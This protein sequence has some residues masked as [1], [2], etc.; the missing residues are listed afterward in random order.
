ME[1]P[2]NSIAGHVLAP[3]GAAVA[4]LGLGT[5]ALNLQAAAGDLSGSVDRLWE[6]AMTAV[7]FAG[8]DGGRTAAPAAGIRGG[9]AACCG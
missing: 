1:K 4:A 7:A 6:N 3:L 2:A 5:A 9:G 8:G